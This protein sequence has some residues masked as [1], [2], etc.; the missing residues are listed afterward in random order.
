MHTRTKMPVKPLAEEQFL[1]I[2][3]WD[4]KTRG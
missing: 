2:L 1:D 3:L 4:R